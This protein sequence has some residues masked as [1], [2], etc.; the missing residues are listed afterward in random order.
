[1]YTAS[2]DKT[3]RCWE[4]ATGKVK[5]SQYKR[6]DKVVLF[7]PAIDGDPVQVR[8]GSETDCFVAR[9]CFGFRSSS[10]VHLRSFPCVIMPLS[11][12]RSPFL[13]F[14]TANA[15]AI[16]LTPHVCRLLSRCSASRSRTGSCTLAAGTKS[17][18]PTSRPR[19]RQSMKWTVRWMLSPWNGC[20]EF[21]EWM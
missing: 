9:V 18:G 11:R 19:W 3:I 10:P 7:L 4:L 20:D 15:N 21:M 13:R 1:M 16:S 12:P 5:G 6:L 8:L 2:W 14:A 17:C